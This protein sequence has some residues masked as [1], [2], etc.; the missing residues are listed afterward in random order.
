[1]P[2][3]ERIVRFQFD[4]PNEILI[5][6]GNTSNPST[7]QMQSLPAS[8]HIPFFDPSHHLAQCTVSYRV[9]A[10][11]MSSDTVLAE[12]SRNIRLFPTLGN[13]PP[14]CTTDFPGEYA[15]S[16]SK[17]IRSRFGLQKLGHLS[18]E[19][20]EPQPFEFYRLKDKASTKILLKLHFPQAHNST[21]ENRPECTDC[22]VTSKLR[23]T[24]FVSVIPQKC[25]PTTQEAQ[26]SPFLVKESRFC[27]WNKCTLHFPRWRRTMQGTTTLGEISLQ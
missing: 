5:P 2:G 26:T 8:L 9:R 3:N 22:I 19:A 18:I 7:A 24:T 10:Q 23:A 1:M 16:A 4:I 25:I 14:L 27:G 20:V 17:A 11:A 12:T 13:Q 15:L 21:E 6:A